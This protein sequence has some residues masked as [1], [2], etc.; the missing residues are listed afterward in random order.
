VEALARHLEAHYGIDISRLDELDQ[1]VVQV[2]RNDGPS[3]VAR[4]FPPERSRADVEGDA[5]ILRLLERFPAERCAHPDAVSELE[6]RQVLVTEFVAGQRAGPGRRTFATLAVLLGMMHERSWR[7]ELRAGG[8]WHH[9]T[10]RGGPAAEIAATAA[11]LEAAQPA[12]GRDRADRDALR[13]EL[14]QSDDGGGLPEALLHPDFVPANAIRTPE[15]RL[16]VV[17]WS[18]AG[19]GPRLW[20]LAFLLYAAGARDLELVDDLVPRYCAH[21]ALQPA[22]LERLAAVMRVRPLVL[23]C[24][25]HLNR[26]GRLGPLV[27]RLAELR[28]RSQ[29][30]AERAR[31]ACEQLEVAA[32]E[33]RRGEQSRSRADGRA[34]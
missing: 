17:D 34:E 4:R 20:A 27:E 8:G 11:L 2:E 10:P 28:D 29:A 5:A 16:V 12:R 22:E 7:L 13:D 1:E 6:G 21:A 26:P 3:W 23:D 9:V 30:V 15:G 31:R 32:R 33:P 25:V 24:W 18:G 19:R 14:A